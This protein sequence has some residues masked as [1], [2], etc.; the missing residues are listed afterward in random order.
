LCAAVA[1][2]SGQQSGGALE[3]ST[4]TFAAASASSRATSPYG[5]GAVRD[6]AGGGAEDCVPRARGAEK[7]A[8]PGTA[9]GE[10][11]REVVCGR[12]GR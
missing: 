2:G 9:G 7:V 1:G 12:G 3:P 6:L 5:A 8:L 10:V 4:G 11:A